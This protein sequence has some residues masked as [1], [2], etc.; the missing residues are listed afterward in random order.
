[1]EELVAKPNSGTNSP[2]FINLG[3]KF[4][5]KDIKVRAESPGLI[6]SASAKLLIIQCR[7][8][9][10]KPVISHIG[11]TSWHAVNNLGIGNLG[12]GRSKEVSQ[13]LFQGR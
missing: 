8:S 13:G 1:M 12:R 5:G 2:V 7:K 6:H 4:E 10:I 11:V 9:F 3:L